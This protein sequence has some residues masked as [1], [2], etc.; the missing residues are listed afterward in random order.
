MNHSHSRAQI[1]SSTLSLA[2]HVLSRIL[3]K[4]EEGSGTGSGEHLRSVER[5]ADLPVAKHFSSPGHTTDDMMVSVVRSV[6]TNI[7]E[8]RSTEDRL[9]FKCR[10]RHAAARHKRGLQFYLNGPG[11]EKLSAAL[12]WT[13]SA[14]VSHV[15]TFK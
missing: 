8:R 3:V 9:I 15:A 6:L 1:A 2:V 14:R 12:K 10:T 11:R 4:Q 7:K 13:L 5:K